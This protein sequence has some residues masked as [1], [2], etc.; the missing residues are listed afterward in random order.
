MATQNMATRKGD[1]TLAMVQAAQRE[2][3]FPERMR[4]ESASGRVVIS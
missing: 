4:D 2:Q 1:S 3:L